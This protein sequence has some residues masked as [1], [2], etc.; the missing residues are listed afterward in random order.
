VRRGATYQPHLSTHRR[1]EY[2]RLR[3]RLGEGHH[4]AIEAAADRE[5]VLARFD[6]F[7]T[8][9]ASG[10]KGAGGTALASDGARAAFAHAAVAARAAAGAARIHSLRVDG[11]AI[12]SLVSFVCGETAFTWKIAYDESFARF[13]PGAQ[14]MVAAIEGLLAEP[15]VS[16]L[17]SCAG[18]NHALADPLLAD[19]MPVGTFVMSPVGEGRRYRAGLAAARLEAAAIATAKR[20]RDRVRSIG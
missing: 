19:R 3:R 17:D 5:T 7:L 9:E 20:V 11:R 4:V 14:V 6:E 1:R 15:E 18:P 12:A 16:R 8:L 10:W 13:S 2:A